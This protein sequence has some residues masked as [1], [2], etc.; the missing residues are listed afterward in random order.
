[1]EQIATEGR[2]LAHGL[3]S[4]VLDVLLFCFVVTAASSLVHKVVFHGR[5]HVQLANFGLPVQFPLSHGTIWAL[6]G[7]QNMH[8]HSIDRTVCCF[9]GTYTVDRIDLDF[10]IHCLRSVRLLLPPV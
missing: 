9:R 2:A 1:M 3:T 8:C 5:L 4:E 6:N 7:E 10:F